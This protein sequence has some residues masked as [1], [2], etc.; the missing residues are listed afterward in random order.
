[1]ESS[2]V[3]FVSFTKPMIDCL[4]RNEFG[5]TVGDVPLFVQSLDDQLIAGQRHSVLGEW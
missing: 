2:A 5:L 4:K 3:L 1:M